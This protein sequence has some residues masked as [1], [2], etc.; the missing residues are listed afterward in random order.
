MAKTW[1]SVKTRRMVKT[2]RPVKSRRMVKTR[3]L[4]KTRRMVK[5]RLQVKTWG[6]VKTQRP[7]NLW[8]LAKCRRPQKCWRS[9][10]SGRIFWRT[11]YCLGSA[12][13]ATADSSLVPLMSTFSSLLMLNHVHVVSKRGM[14]P[15]CP[16]FMGGL[17]PVPCRLLVL[18]RHAQKWSKTRCLEWNSESFLFRRTAGIPSEIPICSGYSV[19][20]LIIFLSQIP[21]PSSEPSWYPSGEPQT[22]FR[23]AA[24]TLSDET[25]KFFLVQCH[26]NILTGAESEG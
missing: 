22:V 20:R 8:R 1:R 14:S 18:A 4:V 26:V 3:H 16:A 11:P 23:M 24:Y 19:F 12:E 9:R 6:M 17:S 21:D 15:P 7:S 10:K 2:R 25:R 13:S 5:T